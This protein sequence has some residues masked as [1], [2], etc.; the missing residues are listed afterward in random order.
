MTIEFKNPP[1]PSKPAGKPIGAETQAIIDALKARPG[2][3]ALIKKDV[4]PN[5]SS[6]W[7]KRPGVE[8]KAST[9]GHAKNKCDVYARWVGT[10]P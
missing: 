9:I 2:E 8:A 4:N 5:T 1:K 3:W 6:W 7:K 10:T